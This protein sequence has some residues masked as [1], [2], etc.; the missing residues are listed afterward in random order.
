MVYDWGP[1]DFREKKTLELMWGAAV[2]VMGLREKF[3]LR[4]SENFGRGEGNHIL[5]PRDPHIS[6]PSLRRRHWCS[7]C[8]VRG[9][10]LQ[11]VEDVAGR[12]PP[13]ARAEGELNVRDALGGANFA[14]EVGLVHPRADL[15]HLCLVHWVLDEA[16]HWPRVGKEPDAAAY[17]YENRRFT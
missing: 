4:L 13:F 8:A 2:V 11:V 6:A 14:W 3:L 5:T 10:Y 12:E 17:V 15:L 7:L 16:S 1:L 9:A